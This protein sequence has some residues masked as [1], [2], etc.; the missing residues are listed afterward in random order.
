MACELSHNRL[1]MFQ[2][3]WLI[4]WWGLSL[5]QK[6]QTEL[7]TTQ[8]NGHLD[9]ESRRKYVDK[10]SKTLGCLL[11]PEMFREIPKGFFQ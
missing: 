7:Y 3:K 6:E 4:Q 5:R 11:L 8:R 2:Q 1:V 10:V 9:A